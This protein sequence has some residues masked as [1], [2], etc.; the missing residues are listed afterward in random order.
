MA[1]LVFNVSLSMSKGRPNSRYKVRGVR[2]WI[3]K[4]PQVRFVSRHAQKHHVIRIAQRLRKLGRARAS[5]ELSN[6]RASLF[7]CVGIIFRRALN[8]FMSAANFNLSLV[9]ATEP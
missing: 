5:L 1:K 9:T 6:A 7:R 3:T 8:G 4:G 2:G